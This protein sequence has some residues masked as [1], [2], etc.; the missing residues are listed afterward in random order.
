MDNTK[1][2]I[3]R[4]KI[5]N[6]VIDEM[7]EGRQK[8]A[9]FT[10][11]YILRELKSKEMLTV[12]LGILAEYLNVSTLSK[13]MKTI[14]SA[15]NYLI[16]EELVEVYSDR[17]G[18]EKLDDVDDVK[19]NTLI[20]IRTEETSSEAFF[21]LIDV[22]DIDK[23]YYQESEE[24]IEDMVVMLALLSRQIERRDEVL[25][26]AWFSQD[27]LVSLLKISTNRYKPLIEEMKRLEVIYF[28]K[29]QIGKKSHYVYSMYENS[30]DVSQAIEVAERN[31]KL[32]VRVKLKTSDV[33]EANVVELAVD[34]DT[35]GIEW[36]ATTYEIQQLLNEVKYELNK[37]SAQMLNRFA[38]VKTKEVLVKTIK[39]IA[40]DKIDGTGTYS[41]V[42]SL[43]N[44]T[45]YFM[46]HFK[47]QLIA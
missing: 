27:R 21:T 1:D 8:R 23:L 4:L 26:I 39:A 36:V 2:F 6:K 7:L 12:N 22:E 14:K 19:T 43:H 42:I 16:E 24:K 9:L 44:P 37:N 18:K 5:D 29:A 35:G 15:V 30:E 34:E 41:N 33:D 11:I 40:G 32:D 3:F 13:N 20:H 10:Y 38:Q 28:D 45:G 17:F 46:N 31:R 47:E 25:Q